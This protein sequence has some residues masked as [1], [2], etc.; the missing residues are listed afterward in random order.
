[1]F[2]LKKQGWD[3]RVSVAPY[4]DLPLAT[5][6]VFHFHDTEFLNLRD[7][8]KQANYEE[9]RALVWLESCGLKRAL[10]MLE[11]YQDVT[12]VAIHVEF[13]KADDHSRW[14]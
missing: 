12:L 9:Q 14:K 2:F 6:F 5:T 3:R 10:V 8:S 11:N 1:M 4:H 13:K 7:E